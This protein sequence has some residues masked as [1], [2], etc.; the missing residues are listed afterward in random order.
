MTENEKPKIRVAVVDDHPMV[1]RGLVSLIKSIDDFEFCGEAS[2][3][4]EAVDLADRIAPDVMLMDL[5]MDQLDGASA[6]AIIRERN[7]KI[8]IVAVTSFHEHNLVQNVLRSGAAGYLLKTATGDEIESAIRMARAGK[9]ILSM[10]ATEA[11][12]QAREHSEVGSDLTDREREIL[13]L[14]AQGKGNQDIATL[15]FIRIPT[16]KF[17]VSNIMAKLSVKNRTEAVLLALKHNL[18]SSA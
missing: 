3:G 2:N 6:T 12:L 13:S 18:V 16:V 1:R 9:R 5:V 15:L 14:L 17:H 10:E 7:S 8:Q 11:L 4:R